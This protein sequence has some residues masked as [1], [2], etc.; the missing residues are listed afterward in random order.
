MSDKKSAIIKYDGDTLCLYLKDSVTAVSVDGLKG[1]HLVFKHP[2]T[3]NSLHEFFCDSQSAEIDAS[4]L[5]YRLP[6][7]AATNNVLAANA[8][9]M[10]NHV[11]VDVHPVDN[12]DMQL[13]EIYI[14]EAIID[15]TL[16]VKSDRAAP[17]ATPYIR[18]EHEPLNKVEVKAESDIK[19]AN[20]QESVS[21]AASQSSVSAPSGSAKKGM[22]KGVL[23]GI[24]LGVIALLALI[25]GLLYYLF[26]NNNSSAAS[27]SSADAVQEEQAVEE[28]ASEVSEPVSAPEAS[29]PAAAPAAAAPCSLSGESDNVILKKCLAS[30]PDAVLLKSFASDAFAAKRCDL[31]KKVLF[32]YGR[33][34][35]SVALTLGALFDPNSNSQTECISKD[36]T[37]AVYWY[38][39]AL[40]LGDN[41]Q[42]K[43]AISKLK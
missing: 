4:V 31:G 23:I 29:Q 17:G 42:A 26:S 7:D 20:A 16:S 33:H 3:H 21:K 40:K 22:S 6:L 2:H 36:R 24:I 43:E 25:A 18:E 10:Q 13:P 35:M 27:A 19:D 34:D 15:G 38:E 39:T 28:T 32:G 5:G 12:A 9:A 14:Y 11:E 1:L 41:D 8:N 30:S 37:Q